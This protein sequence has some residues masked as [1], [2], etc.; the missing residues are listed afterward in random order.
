MWAEL[1]TPLLWFWGIRGPCTIVAET[2]LEAKGYPCLTAS[3][4]CSSTEA[5]E[6]HQQPR[7]SWTVS[8]PR[9]SRREYS[10]PIT[11]IWVLWDSTE[12][13]QL[14]HTISG[15]LTHR[16]CEI[17]KN[18]MNILLCHWI[19]GNF[20]S[21]RKRTDP[22]T[23]ITNTKVQ[24]SYSYP[25]KSGYSNLPEAIPM[26]WKRHSPILNSPMWRTF[27]NVSHVF[28][29]VASYSEVKLLFVLLAIHH[30]VMDPRLL[31]CA[32]WHWDTAAYSVI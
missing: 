25:Q 7:C 21:N 13:N 18:H 2:F 14:S 27:Q 19:C 28:T 16:N 4:Q 31:W 6:F 32:G 17:T 9:A 22:P 12:S 15:L 26:T 24:W 10:P 23:K 8:F 30:A 11:L 20:Y 5:V 1:D 29:C 3:T